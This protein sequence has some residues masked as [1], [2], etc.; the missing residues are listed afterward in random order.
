M[1]SLEGRVAL[2]TGGASGI[3]REV[4]RQLVANGAAVA[5]ADINIAGAAEVA[6]ELVASGARAISVELDVADATSVNAAVAKTIVK[7]G[8]LHILVHSAGVG[9]ERG[10]LETSEEEWRRIIDVD[11]TGTCFCGHAAARAER[12]RR[13]ARGSPGASR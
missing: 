13:R 12:R 6:A 10:F 4:A 2:V 11:L 7:L 8:N 3:G 9:V 5:V 1:G